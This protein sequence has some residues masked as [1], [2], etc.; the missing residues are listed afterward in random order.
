MKLRWREFIVAFLM[1]VVLWYGVSGSEKLESHLEV[2]VDYRGLPQGLVVLSGQVNKVTV[3]VR[4]S[5]GMLRSMSGRDFA[6]FMDMSD[7][8]KGENVLA[9]NLA[10]LPFRS[11]VEVIDVSPSRIIL[12]VD[13]LERKTVP[14][15]GRITGQLP[16][17]YIAEVS[18]APTEVTL[19]G[20]SSL[21][22]ELDKVDVPVPL[23]ES[24]RPGLTEGKRLLALPDGVDSTPNEV[25]QKVHIG[26]KRKLVT[27]QR[28]IQVDMPANFGKFV[29]P[30]KVGIAVA[31]PESLAAKAASNLD[32]R[33][34][35]RLE[36]PELGSHTLPVLVSLPEGAE[37]VEVNPP[38]VTVTVEQ[39]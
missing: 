16:K 23:E 12:E 5:I 24:V 17:D 10:Y 13:T 30:D 15:E 14:L 31:M 26:I 18:Y 4:A 2:R 21:L 36:K 37:L 9:V 1:A 22:A 29:R 33:A 19:S 32:I 7:V 39:K 35:V 8:K 25:L 6:F 20:A 38:K 11:G 27:V 28:T 34:F 3:R